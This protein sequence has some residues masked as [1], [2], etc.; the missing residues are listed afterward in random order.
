MMLER[1]DIM[2]KRALEYLN[3]GETVFFAV[4]CAHLVGETGLLNGLAQAGCTVTQIHYG[5]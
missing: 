5:V 2:V 4:G 3:S 1:N